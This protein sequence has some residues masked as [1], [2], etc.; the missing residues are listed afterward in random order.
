M[1]NRKITIGRDKKCDLAIED[2]PRNAK[3]S[4]RHATIT[5]AD[6]S[7]ERLFVLEDH[8]TNGTY[9]NSKFVHNGTFYVREGDV[10]SLGPDYILEWGLIMPFFGGRITKRKPI[11]KE[12]VINIQN[13]TA[14]NKDYVSADPVYPDPLPMIDDGPSKPIID[15]KIT[16]TDKKEFVFTGWHW[17]IILGATI[18]GFVLGILVNL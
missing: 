16:E 8:S 17:L 14:P 13:G 1:G 11:E 6:D 3:V 12:T 5:E 2:V 9:I 4:G 10:I 18:V 15:D 7:K